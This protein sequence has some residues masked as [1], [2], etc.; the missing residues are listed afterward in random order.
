MPLIASS[1]EYSSKTLE[2][3][4][5]RKSRHALSRELNCDEVS[6]GT[7]T[8]PIIALKGGDF[9]SLQIYDYPVVIVRDSG[10]ERTS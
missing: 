3:I 5:Q 10:T 2:L 6:I 9:I 4:Y 8:L 7:G 1:N